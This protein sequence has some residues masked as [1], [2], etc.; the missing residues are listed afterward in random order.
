RY[1]GSRY[2]DPENTVQA[3]AFTTFDAGIGY[4]IGRWSV[5]L[6]GRNLNDRRDPVSN[7]ELG[8][9]QS[10]VLPGRFLEL[11]ATYRL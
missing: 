6:Q 10:Y 11:S 3:D 5:N 1:V 2:F 9:S 7:S 4:R 8:D